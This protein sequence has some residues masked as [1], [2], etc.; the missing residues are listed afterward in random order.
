MKMI[1]RPFASFLNPIIHEFSEMT[2]ELD[3]HASTHRPER[4]A[5]ELKSSAV[6]AANLS[7]QQDRTPTRNVKGKGKGKARDMTEA[8]LSIHTAHSSVVLGIDSIDALQSKG[9]LLFCKSQV[10]VHP[11]KKRSDNIAGY[12]GLAKVQLAANNPKPSVVLFWVPASLTEALD[13]EDGYQKVSRKTE[14][15][16]EGQAQPSA[17][18]NCDDSSDGRYRLSSSQF[19]YS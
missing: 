5:A 7:G 15:S 4:P 14:S 9:T 3:E 19:L 16:G 8:N 13:E 1:T 11:S 17:N 18:I 12:L 10:Y 2:S 6:S